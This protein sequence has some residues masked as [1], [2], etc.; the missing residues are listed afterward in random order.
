MWGTLGLEGTPS[1]AGWESAAALG[2]QSGHQLNKA[3]ILVAKIEDEAI[4]PIVK[5]LSEP[6]VQEV[7]KQAP[8]VKPLITLDDFKKVELKLAKVIAAERVPKSEKLLKIQ[9]EIGSEKRQVVAGIAQHYKPEDLVGKLIVVVANLQPAK[10]MGQESQGMLLAA[11]D[12]AGKLAVL[13]VADSLE[14]GAPIK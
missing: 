5:S 11:T 4:D 8:E 1:A 14:S 6:P 3:E 7:P 2:L 9:V 13:T 10:L 12:S